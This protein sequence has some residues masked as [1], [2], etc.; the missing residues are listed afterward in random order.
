M[1]PWMPRAV[2]KLGIRETPG[3]ANNPT[4]MGWAKGLGVKIL[5]IVYADDSA[6][7][8]CGLFVAEVMSEAGFRPPPIAVRAKAWATWGTEVAPCEGAVLVF[9]RP[10]GGHVGFYAGE[11]SSA[12]RVLGGNQGDAVSYAWIARDRCIACRWPPGGPPVGARLQ[13]AGAGPLSNNEA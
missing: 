10:G 5:G 12:F 13:V 11:T 1:P 9:Q 2:A 7:P 6:V 3:P 4:I 8:W